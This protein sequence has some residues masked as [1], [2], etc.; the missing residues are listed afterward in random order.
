M[1]STYPL[2]LILL[3]VLEVIVLGDAT[4]KQIDA[5]AGFEI[6]FTAFILLL[7]GPLLG[8]GAVGRRGG[9]RLL[10]LLGIGLILCS[11]SP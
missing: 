1:Q 4:E 9:R 3:H 11:S 10:L 6:S 8:G 7:L 5:L 2:L